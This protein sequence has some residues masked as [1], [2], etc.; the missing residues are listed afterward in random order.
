[1]PRLIASLL[2]VLVLGAAPANA[3]RAGRAES[4]LSAQAPRALLPANRVVAYYGNPV[5]PIL[6]RL[7]EF[8]PD[9]MIARLHQT[10]ATYADA[11]PSRPIKPALE[12][13]TPLAQRSPG[14]DG[15]YRVR[16][17][18]ELIQEVAGWA[19]DND[20]LLI[21]DVQIGRSSVADEPAELLPYLGRHDTHLALDPEFAMGSGQVPGEAIGS[22]DASDIN[23]AIRTLAELVEGA[24]LPPKM[25]IVHQFLPS[26]ITNGELIEPDPRVQVVFVMDG[27]GGPATKI[28]KYGTFIH[29][30]GVN[31][32]GMKLFYK[33]D[34][35]LLQPDDVLGLDPSPDVII[36]Q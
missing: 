30:A 10:V 11:D 3:E 5:S 16:M 32:G 29:D 22:L 17:T 21:L 33:Y 25:L 24:G 26:M 36:Y 2:F 19:A 15:L 12:L 14:D 9:E 4:P 8:P 20:L 23:F 7:G 31:F 1:M 27:F 28:S 18:D 34:S 13:I 35:P 6:G